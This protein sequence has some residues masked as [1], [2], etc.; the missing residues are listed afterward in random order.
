M[1]E[2]KRVLAIIPAREGSKGIKDKNVSACNGKPLIA[3]TIE[4]AKK[5][6]EIDR[7]IVSTD[8]ARYRDILEHDYG[9]ELFPFFRPE[10]YAKDKTP[11]SDVVIHALDK[12]EE[13]EEGPFDI[14]VL[15]EPTSPLRTPEQINEAIQLLKQAPKARALVSVVEDSNHHPLLAFEIDKDKRLVPY[16][17]EHNKEY[18]GHPRRQALRPAYFMSGDLYL[19]YVDTYRE[20]KSFNHELT[21]AYKVEHWQAPEVDEPHDLIVV[22]ALLKARQGGKI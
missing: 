14:V 3:W 8:S 12:L 2:K 6:G 17:Q 10:K 9:E 13:L 15:L 19:S 5:A 18:P 22:D 11:S 4:A 21:A 20:R 16:G 7:L 1:T